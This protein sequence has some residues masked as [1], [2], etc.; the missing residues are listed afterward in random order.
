MK[1]LMEM[2]EILFSMVILKTR[3]FAVRR[4][5]LSSALTVCGDNRDNANC[6]CVM[7]IATDAVL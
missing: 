4:L 2:R 1:H 5:L 6:L 7:S 3:L